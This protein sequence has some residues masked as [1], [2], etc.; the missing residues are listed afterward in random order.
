MIVCKVLVG[1]V[2]RRAQII[3]KPVIVY[4]TIYSN[5]ST[6]NMPLSPQW[7]NI[8]S[9]LHANLDHAS[10]SND[11]IF[12]DKAFNGLAIKISFEKSRL[13][14]PGIG[15]FDAIQVLSQCPHFLTLATEDAESLID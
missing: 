15:K 11:R 7:V 6:S 9:I 14:M 4:C 5:Q 12:L 2:W 13:Y 8:K 3:R 10:F 1:A